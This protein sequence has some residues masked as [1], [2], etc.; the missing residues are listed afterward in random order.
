MVRYVRSE[1]S[2]CSGTFQFLTLT[3]FCGT[4]AFPRS[5]V[6]ERIRGKGPCSSGDPSAPRRAAQPLPSRLAEPDP[7]SPRW[8]G[9]RSC[10]QENSRQP[11][12]HSA[13][14]PVCWRLTF[15]CHVA[16]EGLEILRPH[17]SQ[18]CGEKSFLCKSPFRRNRITLGG[19]SPPEG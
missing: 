8:V 7:G 2:F 10:Q 19:Q 9:P 17:G 11:A 16:M 5:K 3:S 12:Q 13:R 6:S 14:W 1:A 18:L 15:S 4:Q